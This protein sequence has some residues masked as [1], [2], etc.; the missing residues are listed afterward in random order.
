LSTNS[1]ELLRTEGVRKEVV[2]K[3][4]AATFAS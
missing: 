1:Q 4:D 2:T 3:A